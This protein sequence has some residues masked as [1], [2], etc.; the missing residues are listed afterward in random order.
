MYHLASLI[1]LAFSVSPSI[2][3]PPPD[4]GFP[5]SPNDTALVITYQSNGDPTVVTEAELFGVNGGRYPAAH[6]G[7]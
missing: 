2:A 5:E 6:R 3:I 4:F 1:L 7:Y